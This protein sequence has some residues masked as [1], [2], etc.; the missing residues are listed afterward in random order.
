[1][2]FKL[3]LKYMQDVIKK[4]LALI[5]LFTLSCLVIFT[6]AS[7]DFHYLRLTKAN[8]LKPNIQTS[9]EPQQS[10]EEREYI[11][12]L[13][14]RKQ[15][16]AENIK[17]IEAYL[18][19]GNRNANYGVYFADLNSDPSTPTFFY[20][21][22]PDKSF[23]PASTYKVPLAM[24][25]LR[26]ADQGSIDLNTKV[27]HMGKI[28]SLKTIF[29]LMIQ[30]SDNDAMTIFEK[31]LGGYEKV[32]QSIKNDFGVEV[33]RPGQKVT[34]TA[35][36]TIFKHL[37]TNPESYLSESS[38][39]YLLDLMETAVSWLRDRIPAAI[40]KFN[41]ENGTNLRAS[42]K[43]GNLNGIYQDAGLIL[44][45]K[46][47][48]VLVILNQNRKTS[49]EAINEIDTITRTLLTGLE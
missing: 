16:L 7:R 47:D 35:L 13:D 12:G 24:L 23:A 41:T 30:E 33:I 40:D 49:T 9:Q 8:S 10:A 29:E 37:Y 31:Q 15:K 28:K 38:R 3:V 45:G 25:V 44:G 11:A 34:P 18:N 36:A 22:N 48:Y 32:Q 2:Q 17:A 6:L 5:A 1:M 20:S 21:H 43:I 27:Y 4:R 39:Q 46:N 14:N 26:A 42:T 19:Q